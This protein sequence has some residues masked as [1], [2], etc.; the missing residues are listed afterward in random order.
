MTEAIG[1]ASGVETAGGKVGTQDRTLY[2]IQHLRFVAAMMVVLTHALG[3]IADRDPDGI[4]PDWRVGV[5]GVDIFFVISGFI[6]VLITE[7]Q[8][9]GPLTFWL[10]R[11]RRIVPLYWTATILAFI[12]GTMVPHY[13]FNRAS[14]DETIRSLLFVPFVH[15]GRD[16]L[17]VVRPGWT[18]NLE[19]AFYTI[20]SLALV[21]RKAYLLVTL[22]AL[23][24]SYSAASVFSRVDPV[25][26]FYAAHAYI[27]EFSLGI[28][29]A[30][31]IRNQKI[32]PL[33]G[34]TLIVLGFSFLFM[35]WP[36]HIK[37]GPFFA[38]GIPAFI[39]VAGAIVSEPYC[40]GSVSVRLSVLGDASFALY[41]SHMFLIAPLNRMMIREQI[42]LEPI[43]AA[44]IMILGAIFLGLAV[45]WW[46]EVPVA[47]FLK[48]RQWPP[49][50]RGDQGVAGRG[51]A[52]AVLSAM[53]SHPARSGNDGA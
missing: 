34:P 36:N 4:I 30:L 2:G 47:R 27:L 16:V 40:R 7:N 52:G 24:A 12:L 9:A 44:V 31:V 50:V 8:T 15:P 42:V 39:I 3:S 25:V 53:S 26:G 21:F 49:G 46:F 32:H 37:L 6:M 10:G 48:G 28:L 41:L 38:S 23:F 14:I 33:W 5:T 13:F 51:D 1:K 43:T 11:V 35:L 19:M 45:H 22:V 29:L 18:L 20:L 17:P